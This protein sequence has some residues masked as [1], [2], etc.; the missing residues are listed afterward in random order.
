M[1]TFP[2]GPCFTGQTV[3]QGCTNS[4]QNLSGRPLPNAPKWSAN[5][6]AEYARPISGHLSALVDVS[7][8]W[9][10]K[11]IYNL[12]QDPDSVQPA[13]G[14]FNLTAGLEAQNWKAT[15]FVR[16]LFDRNYALTR[17]RSNSFNISP[18]A[19]PFTDAINWTPGRDSSR[20]FGGEVSVS[21]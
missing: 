11:V 9:Q 10:S 8:R 4:L 13:Y 17:G 14:L 3:A 2:L 16:N 15:I 6:N 18:G 5:L 20:Y 1:V 12:T 19:P 21:F 7:Y